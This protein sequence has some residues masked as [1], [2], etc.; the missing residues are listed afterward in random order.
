MESKKLFET[1]EMTKNNPFFTHKVLCQEVYIT[2]NR[3]GLFLILTS[4][5]VPS[6]FW[7]PLSSNSVKGVH[8]TN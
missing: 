5:E 2:C 4:Y 7:F 3:F 8:E 6:N 1:Y